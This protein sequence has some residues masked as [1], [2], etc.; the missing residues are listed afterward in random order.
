[1]IYR[2]DIINDKTTEELWKFIKEHLKFRPSYHNDNSDLPTFDFREFKYLE[3][4]ISK[5]RFDSRLYQ[6]EFERIVANILDEDEFVYV[7][8]WQHQSFVYDP[9]IKKLHPNV[10]ITNS[11][12]VYEYT[13]EGDIFYESLPTFYPN[14]D[15]FF[16]VSSKYK[17]Y[18]FS[19]P[20]KKRIWI[21]GEEFQNEVRN[22]KLNDHLVQV[23]GTSQK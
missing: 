2:Y 16:F 14:G 17:W 20:W 22:S 7:L 5:M 8:D 21:I 12:E 23:G 11:G 1:M 19:H 4:D 10:A 15:Y 13:S 9:R 3:Y 6:S 18:Y